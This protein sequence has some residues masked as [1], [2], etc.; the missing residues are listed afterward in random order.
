MSA[1][2]EQSPHALLPL[3]EHDIATHNQSA[4]RYLA[5]L[6]GRAPDGEAASH[7]GFVD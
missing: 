6:E 7:V 4:D 5:S 3:P 2:I 1:G